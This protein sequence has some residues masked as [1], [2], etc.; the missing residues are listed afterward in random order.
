MAAESG[1]RAQL[2]L[3]GDSLTG[4]AHRIVGSG[5]DGLA[6]SPDGRTLA[7]PIPSIFYTTIY[8]Q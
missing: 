5:D 1:E 4:N 3:V 7:L 8:L 2:K 6:L